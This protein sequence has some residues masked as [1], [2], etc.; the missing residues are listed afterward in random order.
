M[1]WPSASAGGDSARCW[2]L[3]AGQAAAPGREG[4]RVTGVELRGAQRQTNRRRAVPPGKVR[5]RRR[6]RPRPAHQPETALRSGA[7]A[8]SGLQLRLATEQKENRLA[9]PERRRVT[10]NVCAVP[11]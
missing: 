1:Q 8:F 3:L 7:V 6:P 5:T 11:R 9:L 4:V 10:S 2:R